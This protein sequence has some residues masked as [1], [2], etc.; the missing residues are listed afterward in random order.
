M[1][2]LTKAVLT[3]T[4]FHSVF[5]HPINQPD[6][7]D[8]RQ[9]RR[10]LIAEESKELLEAVNDNNHVEIVDALADCVYVI[11]GTIVAV[12]GDNL[13]FDENELEMLSV[14]SGL[15]TMG[16]SPRQDLLVVASELSEFAEQLLDPAF[17]KQEIIELSGLLLFRIE[18]LCGDLQISIIPAVLEAHR[19]NITK[20]WTED[21]EARLQQ[22]A[23]DPIRYADMAFRPRSDGGRGLVGYRLSDDKILK[24]PTYSKADFNPYVSQMLVE[25]IS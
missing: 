16:N 3:V 25:Q 21:V 8:L 6:T 23:T 20:L 13:N 10:N 14:V 7:A 22:V 15:A 12:D 9:Q 5:D 24:S 18:G 17:T 4:E 19:S 1:S 11:A 2:L